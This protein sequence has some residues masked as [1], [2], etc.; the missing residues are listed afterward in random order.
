MSSRLRARLG[1][2]SSRSLDLRRELL[3]ALLVLV[4]LEVPFGLASLAGPLPASVPLEPRAAWVIALAAA[5][6]LAALWRQEE[7][8][9]RRRLVVPLGI[10]PG[11]HLAWPSV[12][13]LASLDALV[14]LLAAAIVTLRAPT[15]LLVRRHE[16]PPRRRFGWL[17]LLVLTLPGPLATTAWGL[18]A[19]IA[20][21]A[22]ARL[23]HP[24]PPLAP[25]ERSAI[26]R[27]ADGLALEATYWP[28]TV[29]HAV[30]L[31]HGLHDGRDRMLGWARALSARGAHVLA[32][33]QRAHG[34]SEGALVTFA[35]REP[36]DLV[37]AAD[38]LLALSR[39][40]GRRLSVLGASM[41]GG[42]ALAAMP[43][44]TARG[45]RRAVL[46]A[47]ASDYEA[48]VGGHLP[49][50]VLGAPARFV[51][52]TVSRALG[53]REPLS[54]R[55][56]EG[57]ARALPDA[58]DLRVVVVHGT[59]DRTIPPALTR[60]LAAAHPAAVEVRWREGGAHAGLERATLDDE[61]LA[62]SLAAFLME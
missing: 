31:V 4:A 38:R 33:D 39:L 42:A 25:S 30:L 20:V 47:P 60:G 19:T 13:W 21:P 58:P 26:V 56:A 22:A 54:L 6:A 57:L 46:L 50:G 8:P 55:P 61:A 62:A 24:A 3:S 9:A 2:G 44:L 52:R 15:R 51:V 10:A 45:L 36:A 1:S 48:L 23:L 17:A 27:T 32:F 16:G 12:P 40:D 11:L 37:A 41:G 43:E 35:D 53:H 14:F 18:A 28:G 29:D 59:A 49:S 34:A 7:S 5:A